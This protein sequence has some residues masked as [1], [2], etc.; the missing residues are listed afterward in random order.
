[1][2]IPSISNKPK[3]YASDDYEYNFARYVEI[4]SISI[5][6]FIN[7]L[8]RQPEISKRPEMLAYKLKISEFFWEY[9]QKQKISCMCLT[10]MKTEM[11]QSMKAY[12]K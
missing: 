9:L 12:D 5:E 4:R 10:C 6:D 3:R 7:F 2:A 1:M 8:L 11:I